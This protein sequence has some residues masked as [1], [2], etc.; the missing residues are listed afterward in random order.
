LVSLRPNLFRVGLRM[1]SAGSGAWPGFDFEDAK[2][3][4]S[5]ARKL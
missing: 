4:P 1:L 2:C 3:S 5:S